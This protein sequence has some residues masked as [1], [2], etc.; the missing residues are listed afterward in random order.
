MITS[1][2]AFNESLNDNDINEKTKTDW[3]QNTINI[4][5][6]QFKR[7]SFNKLFKK[8]IR[9]SKTLQF[10]APTYVEKGVQMEYHIEFVRGNRVVTTR[11][12]SEAQRLI[13]GIK[14][15]GYTMNIRRYDIIDLTIVNEVKPMDD[16][17]ILGTINYK[18]GLVNPAPNREVP[19][20]LLKDINLSGTSY[21]AHCNKNLRRNK[22]V[23]VQNTED[24]EIKQIGGT[25]TKY[26]LGL[27]YNKVLG[28]LQS[29]DEL[30]GTEDFED[31]DWGGYYSQYDPDVFSVD[32]IVKYYVGLVNKTK[33]HMSKKAAAAYNDKVESGGNF[34]QSTGET[35]IDNY[36]YANSPMDT[37]GMNDFEIRRMKERMEKLRKEID[38][39]SSEASD[40]DVQDVY[41]FIETKKTESN[42]MFNVSNKVAEGFLEQGFL[43]FVTGACSFY[44]GVKFAK[45]AK[46]EKMDK[47]IADNADRAANSTHIGTQGEK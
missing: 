45:Q 31:E 47:R 30:G 23:F 10:P 11:D 14:P 42:F 15:E 41:D 32:G 21:C 34:K 6:P 36:T 44:F 35:I 5:I 38:M 46:K 33:A 3:T 18:D 1:F 26:Y 17:E 24:G 12:R 2:T 39:Y 4:V 19:M 20:D 37:R 22:T 27:D 28:Y 7:K 13:K 16:W 8:L 43:R 25:C 9:F 29:L 40:K